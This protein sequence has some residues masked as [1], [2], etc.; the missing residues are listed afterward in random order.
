MY[1][2]MSLSVGEDIPMSLME[3]R[4]GSLKM[5]A[6]SARAVEGS[7]QQGTGVVVVRR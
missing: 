7:M 5:I 2:L 6:T 3:V 4:Q 1:S